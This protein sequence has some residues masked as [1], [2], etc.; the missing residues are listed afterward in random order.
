MQVEPG[1]L[2]SVNFI[3]C[4][5]IIEEPGDAAVSV[6]RIA[7]VFVVR[8]LTPSPDP[9]DI[10]LVPIQ[11][12]ALMKFDNEHPRDHSATIQLVYPDD[13]IVDVIPFIEMPV[14]TAK[15]AVKNSPFGHA[16][17]THSFSVLAGVRLGVEQLG[18]H[19]LTLQIDGKLVAREPLTFAL[20]SWLAGA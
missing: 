9:A 10:E 20:R 19:Y 6:R 18:R 14:H 1:S 4:E 2:I 11:I 7:D 16:N 15:S 13:S 3:V 5:E 17:S 12:A 8:D